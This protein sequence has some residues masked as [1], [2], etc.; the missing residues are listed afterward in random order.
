MKLSRESRSETGRDE[1]KGVG[2][3]APEEGR[4]LYI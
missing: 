2:G 4:I 3:A 1:G